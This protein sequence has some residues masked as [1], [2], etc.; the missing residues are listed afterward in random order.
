MNLSY[1]HDQE[2][3]PEDWVQDLIIKLRSQT[4]PFLIIVK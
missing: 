1:L 3:D 4:K 2:T